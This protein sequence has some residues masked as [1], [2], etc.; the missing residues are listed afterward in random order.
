MPGVLCSETHA[1][2]LHIRQRR[3]YALLRRRGCGPEA[4]RRLYL[5]SPAAS[6]ARARRRLRADWPISAEQPL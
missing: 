4:G 3:F 6:R 2:E 5:P 1:V